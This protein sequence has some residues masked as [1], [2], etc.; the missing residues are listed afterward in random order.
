MIDLAAFDTRLHDRAARTLLRNALTLQAEHK[1]RLSIANPRPHKNSSHAGQYP[2]ARTF[3]LRDAVVIEPASLDV[4]TQSLSVRVGIS[5]SAFYGFILSERGWK[6]L[7]DTHRD[8][9]AAGRYKHVDLP[10]AP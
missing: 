6:G 10:G 1:R 7:H 8:L 5:I 2:K 4:I 3:N 9:T